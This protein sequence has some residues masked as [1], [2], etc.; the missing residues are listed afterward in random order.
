MLFY[1]TLMALPF[2]FNYLIAH[3]LFY[4]SFINFFLHLF[5]KRTK[6][7]LYV[8]QVTGF[9]VLIKKTY[10]NEKNFSHVTY[11]KK[12]IFKLIFHSSKSLNTIYLTYLRY[13]FYSSTFYL[14]PHTNY[15]H[16]FNLN[17]RVSLF[18]INYF[19][20]TK[21]W[22][23]T[24]LFLFN[25]F[26]ANLKPIFFGEPLL[27][28]EIKTLNWF[29]YKNYLFGYPKNFKISNFFSQ[30]GS[31]KKDTLSAL[32]PVSSCDIFIIL[33]IKKI[34]KVSQF[35]PFLL[36]L[37]PLNQNPWLL[38]YPIPVFYQNFLI[39]Y[40]WLHLLFK[41]LKFS[42]HIKFSN[43]INNWKLLFLK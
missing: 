36:G 29:F 6:S 23:N 35:T 26:Y 12:N 10:K 30:A 11:K 40:L 19:S 4:F 9:E 41:I 8:K 32:L 5:S 39:Q 21:K 27:Y 24:Y 33:N 3:S 16:F 1:I 38:D 15:R 13:T 37:T 25:L 28:K 42:I 43:L 17:S 31:F 7:D 20:F 34:M 22:L 18:T 14:K 2:T